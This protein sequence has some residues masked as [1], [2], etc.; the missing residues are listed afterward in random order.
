MSTVLVTGGS[1]FVGIHVVLQLLAAGHTVRTTVRRPERRDEV[2][3]MLREGGVASPHSLSFFTADLTADQGW[4][5]AVAGCDYV[6]HVA[7]PLSTRVPDHEDEMIIPARDG[8]LRVLRAARDAGVKRVVITSSLGAIGYGHP[9]RDAPFDETDWTNLGGADV[10]PYIK[11]KTLAE[12]AAWD[13]VAREGDGLELSVVNPAGIFGPVLGPDF[14]GSIEI[15]KSLLDGAMP[16]VPRVYFGVVDVR[17]VA[18][19]HLRAMTA[20][21]ARGERFIAVSGETMSILDIARLLRRELGPRARRVPRLLAP[22]WV[23]R[24]AATRVPLLQAVVP[25]LGKVRR[26]TSAKARAELGWKARSNEEAI[27]STAESLI[28]LG[29]VK[30]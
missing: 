15:V 21:E 28:R 12:R 13:F 16:A 5:E 2:L 3:T 14:S 18:D 22:D 19:L 9:P 20:P 26:S 29:L 7:S 10:Q 30:A 17:D 6:L 11:S 23:V 4:R 27:L 24:L 1:G 25:M 8:T